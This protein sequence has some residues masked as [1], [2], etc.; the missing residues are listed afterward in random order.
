MEIVFFNN[1]VS[2]TGLLKGWQKS[3]AKGWR[4]QKIYS[5]A[6][7]WA[8]NLIVVDQIRKNNGKISFFHM[9]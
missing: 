3:T 7:L 1:G 2:R 9:I 6:F 8:E 4:S 5:G